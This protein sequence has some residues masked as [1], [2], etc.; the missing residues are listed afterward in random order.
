[1]H[2]TN[3]TREHSIDF[4]NVG[5]RD[6]IQTLDHMNINLKEKI[7]QNFYFQLI[8]VANDNNSTEHD[9]KNNEDNERQY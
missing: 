3:D 7:S 8:A 5:C 6:T 2:L 9:D 4:M 1:M